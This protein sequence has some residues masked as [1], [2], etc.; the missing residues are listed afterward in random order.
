MFG[1]ALLCEIRAITF[2]LFYENRIFFS[3]LSISYY[4]PLLAIIRLFFPSLSIQINS[5]TLKLI[6]LLFKQN[7]AMG[8]KVRKFSSEHDYNNY[9]RKY[10]FFYFLLPYF[11]FPLILYKFKNYFEKE[12]SD[13]FSSIFVNLPIFTPLTYCSLART[14][15]QLQ[16]RSLKII[17]TMISLPCCLGNG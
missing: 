10:I 7:H 11:N 1:T 5:K 14:H 17:N 16:K 12:K 6:P 13:H 3:S 2:Y 15:L 4:Q 9:E 8:S